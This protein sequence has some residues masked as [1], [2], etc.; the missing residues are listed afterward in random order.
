MNIKNS[1]HDYVSD[2]DIDGNSCTQQY[3]C[4]ELFSTIE[5]NYFGHVYVHKIEIFHWQKQAIEKG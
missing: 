3:E 2:I 5:K 1:S 4:R